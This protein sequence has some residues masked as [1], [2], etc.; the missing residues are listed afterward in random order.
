M[1][2]GRAMGL[3]PAPFSATQ[4]SGYKSGRSMI[5]T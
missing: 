2:N 5:G 3:P 1:I 4:P